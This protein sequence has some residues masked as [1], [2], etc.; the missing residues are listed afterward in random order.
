MY[1]W[2]STE[3]TD[4]SLTRCTARYPKGWYLD[5]SNGNKQG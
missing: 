3:W 1:V 2:L 5:P 4:T